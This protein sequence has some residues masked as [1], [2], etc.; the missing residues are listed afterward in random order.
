M[1]DA[2]TVR[3]KVAPGVNIVDVARRAGVSTSTVSRTL[4]GSLNVSEE[5]RRRVLRAASDLAYVPSPAA[6]RL[7]SGRTGTVGV[8]V[9]FVARWFFAEVVRGA[10]AELREAGYDLLLYNVGDLVSRSHLFQTMPL[11]R[12]VDAVLAVATSFSDGERAALDRL[13]VPVVMV[14]DQISPGRAGVGIDDEESAAM[15]VRHLALLGH[16]HIVMI[17]GRAD[18]PIGRETTL[19]RQAGFRA[20]LRAAGLPE[21]PDQIVAEP[22]GVEGG[23]RAMEWLLTRCRLPTAVFAESD[24]MAFG[25]LRTLRRVGL[26]VPGDVSLVGF[27]DHE[28]ALANDLTTIAQPVHEQ[29]RLAARLVLDFV[30]GH[31]ATVHGLTQDSVSRPAPTA[32]V[33]DGSPA[34][35]AVIVLPTRLV[36]RGTTGPPRRDS[37]RTTS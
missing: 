26:D 33:V 12:R 25:A 3:P 15:A 27:D 18:D 34:D 28:L 10:E 35:G 30:T 21:R 16:S 1:T 11:R 9:Q 13:G 36:V 37:L 17:S 4:R 8:I 6:S 31:A 29:G 5:T 32:R 14:G 2:Y 20:G 19:A 22:W 23:R 7:A 24:E